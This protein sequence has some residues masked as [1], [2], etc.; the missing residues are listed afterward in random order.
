MFSADNIVPLLI[1]TASSLG[2]QAMGSEQPVPYAETN[3][4]RAENQCSALVGPCALFRNPMPMDFS[5]SRCSRQFSNR[6][7]Y[8]LRS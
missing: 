2:R 8:T 6:F 5:I 1:T 3:P 7:L 4:P